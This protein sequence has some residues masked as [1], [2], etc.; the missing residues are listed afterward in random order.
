LL[1]YPHLTC[2]TDTKQIQLVFA[3]IKETILSKALQETGI[4]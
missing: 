2:A 1:V 4:I 3:A